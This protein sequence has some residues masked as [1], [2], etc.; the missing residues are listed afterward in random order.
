[1][2]R[3]SQANMSIDPSSMAW[4]GFLPFI[5]PLFILEACK[6]VVPVIVVSELVIFIVEMVRRTKEN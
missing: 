4:V 2:I 1:M 3:E 6:Y 5:F